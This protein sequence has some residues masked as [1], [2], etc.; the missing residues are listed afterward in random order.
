MLSRAANAIYWMTRY[1]E[2]AENIA[3]FTDVN[4]NVT[5]DLPDALGLWESILATTGD[6][7][8][9]RALF[10]KAEK[11]SVLQFLAAEE[12]NPNAILS[13]LSKARENAR[14]VREIISS[15]MWQQ[16]NTAYL[17]AQE[18]TTAGAHLDQPEEFF[19]RVKQ[20][21]HLFDGLMEATM[22]HGEP[23]HFGRL[24][25]QLERAEKTARLLDV[26][27][28][29][30][31]P[32]PTAMDG[33]FDDLQWSAVL[34]SASALEMYRKRRHRITA[35][36]VAD[37]LIFD[38]EFPRSIASCL[39]RAEESLKA[40]TGSPPGTFGN[41]AEKRLGRTRSHVEYLDI[42]D[43]FT[44]GLHDFLKETQTEINYV[45]DGIHE[46]F[47]AMRP[48]AQHPAGAPQ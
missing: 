40:I 37:F 35:R 7:A 20:D 34:R 26:K 45:G 22:S 30:L 41:L 1:I 27:Y 12:T 13:C 19:A 29:A 32:E 42:E 28:Y 2:R 5:L 38:R 33:A 9:F 3:R 23:W 6:E 36:D 15:E 39:S 46:T 24:G 48:V 25:R 11:R 18:A 8:A 17:A 43:V 47:F 44:L 16:V 31:L 4:L 14:S 21:S 10:P